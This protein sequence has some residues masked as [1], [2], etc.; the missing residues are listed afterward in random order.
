MLRTTS[1]LY[2]TRQSIIT[3]YH[4]N[5]KDN[6][7]QAERNA[8]AK[9]IVRLGKGHKRAKEHKMSVFKRGLTEATDYQQGT[10]SAP[11]GASRRLIELVRDDPGFLRGFLT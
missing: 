7:S 8:I 6:L 2:R 10:K 1:R 5:E 3:P 9:I 4:K 11:E